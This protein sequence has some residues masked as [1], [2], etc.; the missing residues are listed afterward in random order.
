M[1]ISHCKTIFIYYTS[2]PLTECMNRKCS[3]KSIRTK[4]TKE[5]MYKKYCRKPKDLENVEILVATSFIPSPRGLKLKFLIEIKYKNKSKMYAITL[6]LGLY[7]ILT[8][9]LT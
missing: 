5:K 4:N 6:Y 7:Y 3:C 1:S 8:V 2:F 9:Q